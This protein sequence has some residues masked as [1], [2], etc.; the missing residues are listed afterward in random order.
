MKR[1]LSSYLIFID[2]G[3]NIRFVV[4]DI[5]VTQYLEG[6]VYWIIKD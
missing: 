6:Y 4:D 1:K 2:M 5:E 3:F